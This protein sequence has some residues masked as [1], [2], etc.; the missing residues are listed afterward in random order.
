MGGSVVG[1]R[2]GAVVRVR[3]AVTLRGP[4]PFELSSHSEGAEQLK[5]VL[6]EGNGVKW[7]DLK[8]TRRLRPKN[9]RLSITPAFR[10]W[11]PGDR[12]VPASR[13][14]AGAAAHVDQRAIP[15]G[16]PTKEE[17]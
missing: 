15:A 14:P 3:K 6:G 7:F 4:L 8:E 9:N 16:G 5:N 12:S 13:I 1:A 2:V 11:L 17:A 10:K